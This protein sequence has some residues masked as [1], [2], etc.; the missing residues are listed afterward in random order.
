M[1]V[2]AKE[3]TSKM[4]RWGAWKCPCFR[5]SAGGLAPVRNEGASVIAR[6]PQ[7]ES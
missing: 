2:T 7:G 4:S 5:N 6:C 3:K 1:S